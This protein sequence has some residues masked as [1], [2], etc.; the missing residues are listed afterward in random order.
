MICLS[1]IVLDKVELECQHNEQKPDVLLLSMRQQLWEPTLAALTAARPKA[2]LGLG[3]A[4]HAFSGVWFQGASQ[5]EGGVYCMGSN[6]SCA[7][8]TGGTQMSSD[9]ALDAYEDALLGSGKTYR[10]LREQ[11]GHMAAFDASLELVLPA[12]SRKEVR[13]T[14]IYSTSRACS[15][16]FTV[17]FV[18]ELFSRKCR[19]LLVV[20]VNLL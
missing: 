11:S 14:A 6:A 17:L 15:R 18:H 7:F 8:V 12:L 10:W 16:A 3:D 5:K 1:Q 2:P 13:D 9:E 4:G 19:T 20:N